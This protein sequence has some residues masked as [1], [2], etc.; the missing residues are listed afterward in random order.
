[1]KLQQQHNK[2]ATQPCVSGVWMTQVY[3]WSSGKCFR[4][5]DGLD[6]GGKRK[7]KR[8]SCLEDFRSWFTGTCETLSSMF[9]ASWTC[10]ARVMFL[11]LVAVNPPEQKLKNGPTFTGAHKLKL[12]HWYKIHMFS[13]FIRTESWSTCNWADLFYRPELH[14]SEISQRQ[15]EDSEED[16]QEGSNVTSCHC[17]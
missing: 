6:E 8:G 14:L 11:S 4:V 7:R 2:R 15:I 17:W 9:M 3:L 5:P 16:L 13:G 10:C 12:N 1:M